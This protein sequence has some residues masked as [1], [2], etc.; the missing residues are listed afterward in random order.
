[1]LYNEGL[2]PKREVTDTMRHSEAQRDTVI[3]VRYTVR[4]KARF[5]VRDIQTRQLFKLCRKGNFPDNS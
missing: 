4:H 1:M 5:T 2:E 3:A